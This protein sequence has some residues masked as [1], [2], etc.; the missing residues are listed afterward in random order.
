MFDIWRC[1]SIMNL[2]VAIEPFWSLEIL[3]FTKGVCL[4]RLFC[5]IILVERGCSSMV[6]H[7]LKNRYVASSN[8]VSSTTRENIIIANTKETSAMGLFLKTHPP[9]QYFLS[10]IFS[11]GGQ[12]LF[13]TFASFSTC[14]HRHPLLK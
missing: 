3:R 8:L 14:M 11:Y 6:E 1:R 4:G 9:S 5:I 2:T 10:P 7:S 13:C 12:A